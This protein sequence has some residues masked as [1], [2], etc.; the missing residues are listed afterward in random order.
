VARIRRDPR[1]S[2][3]PFKRIICGDIPEFESYVAARQSGLWR[4]LPL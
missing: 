2:V 4:Y 1:K 3:R